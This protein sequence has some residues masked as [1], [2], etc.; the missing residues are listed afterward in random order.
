MFSP[1]LGWSRAVSRLLGSFWTRCRTNVGLI[2]SMPIVARW[3]MSGQ[4]PPRQLD[5]SLGKGEHPADPEREQ[6][7]IARRVH[8][9]A[10]KHAVVAEMNDAMRRAQRDVGPGEH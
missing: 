2:Q 1:P 8:A 6:N 7:D 5:E 3:E 4:R 9:Q 10:V